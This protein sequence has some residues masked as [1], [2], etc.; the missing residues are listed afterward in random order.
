M[1]KW[2]CLAL[3]LSLVLASIAYVQ[4]IEGQPPNIIYIRPDGTIEPSTAPIRL[5]DNTYTLEDDI[6]DSSIVVQRSDIVI[7]GANFLLQGERITGTE[8]YVT[9]IGINLT[10]VRY[11]VIKNL[12]LRDFGKGIA[13]ENAENCLLTN[14]TLTTTNGIFL[15]MSSHNQITDNTLVPNV[16][17]RFT[18][19]IAIFALS[20]SFN[21]VTTNQIGGNWHE[22]ITMV[23]SNNVVDG[24]SVTECGLGIQVAGSSNIISGN[25]VFS[26]IRASSEEIFANSGIGIGIGIG[27]ENLVIR[28]IIQDNRVGVGLSGSGSAIYLNKFINNTQQVELFEESAGATWDN[29]KEGN[30]WSDYQSRYPNA[31]ELEY[32]GI[33]NTSYVIDENNID[34]YPL[35]QEAS[36]STPEPTQTPVPTTNTGSIPPTTIITLVVVVTVLSI[37]LVGLF[38]YLRKR[39]K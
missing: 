11:V 14:N 16:D 8:H 30:Y 29:G 23:G 27:S 1:K 20:S 3:L 39:K 34:H 15:N 5:T 28:N 7:D 31:S 36:T 37:S 26:T 6:F 17:S 32:S 21:N 19:N 4:P 13:A 10:Q 25:K 35:M 18:Q 38:V 9:P 24:N 2:V 33:W 22:G 12:E